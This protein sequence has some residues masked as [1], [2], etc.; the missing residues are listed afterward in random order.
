MSENAITKQ[1][2]NRGGVIAEPETDRPDPPLGQPNSIDRI[3]GTIERVARDPSVNVENMER[4]FALQ[5]RLLAIHRKQ[6]FDE[7][8]ARIQDQI[9][10][11]KKDGVIPL[12]NGEKIKFAKFESIQKIVKPML[13]AEGFTTTY[14]EEIPADNPAVKRVVITLS[15]GGHSH[16]CAAFVPVSDPGP[17]RSAAQSMTSATSQGRR[18]AYVNILDITMEGEDDDGAGGLEPITEQQVLDLETALTDSKSNRVKFL[19]WMGVESL[20]EIL[21]RDYDRAMRALENKR[22]AS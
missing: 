2:M 22:K 12:K 1:V 17:A 4:I 7:A 5:E 15:R 3:I 16:S 9:P 13:R 19:R 10:P 11:V 6:E 20:S 18:R 14:T 21:T 8:L